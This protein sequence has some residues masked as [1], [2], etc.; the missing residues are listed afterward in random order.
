MLYLFFQVSQ[1]QNHIKKDEK[2][3]AQ[4]TPITS[5]PIT[6]WRRLRDS[7]V[8]ED[9]KDKNCHQLHPAKRSYYANLNTFCVRQ[10]N[11]Q[12]MSPLTINQCST[13]HSIYQTWED[14]RDH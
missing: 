5:L 7:G 6:I 1:L 14:L 10:T 8:F 4:I 3:T 13:T 11:W 12:I 9:K 2:K